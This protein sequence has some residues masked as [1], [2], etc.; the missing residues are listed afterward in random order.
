[1]KRSLSLTIVPLLI[2]A[3]FLLSG[4]TAADR[5]TALPGGEIQ[6][7]NFSYTAA[8]QEE[9]FVIP[10]DQAGKTFALTAEGNTQ[11]QVSFSLTGPSETEI[12]NPGAFGGEWSFNM[13][14]VAEQAGDYRLTASWSGPVS[15]SYIISWKFQ[16]DNPVKPWALLAG[17]GMVLS[18]FVFVTYAAMKKL[19]GK[20]LLLGAAAWMISVALKFAAAIPLNGPI[21]ELIYTTLAEP[22]AGP[23]FWVYVGLLTGVFEV[24]V[25]YLWLRYTRFG[26]AS[27]KQALAFGIGFGSVEALLLGILNL[28]ST[29]A[30]LLVPDQMGMSALQS[31]AQQNNLLYALAPTAERFFTILIHIFCN[32]ALFYAIN[33]RKPGWFWFSFV[34]KSAIDAI[35][36][37]AQLNWV[38]TLAFLWTI[39]AFVIIFG[40]V[41]LYFTWSISKKYPPVE[42]SPLPPAPPDQ[43]SISAPAELP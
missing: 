30:A 20:Y 40:L 43:P 22:I 6:R 24:A 5:D 8:G 16:G 34:F 33:A 4:C 12:W 15:G 13:Y 10:V 7:D 31:V 18:A 41:G 25:V 36:G 23:V 17:T 42:E 3:L 21:Y 14:P 32:T 19:G 28:I 1:M 27:W 29:G 9:L 26:K 37:Y 11:G 35:A 38:N 39:E 2:L